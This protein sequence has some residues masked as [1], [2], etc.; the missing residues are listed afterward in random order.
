MI[1]AFF[2][3]RGFE[4]AITW[5]FGVQ[6]LDLRFAY[7]EKSSP[8]VLIVES[9]IIEIVSRSFEYVFTWTFYIGRWTFCVQK[10][11]R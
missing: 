8:S 2:V 4:Y 11:R 10:D 7:I 5:T 3:S 9:N 6:V 1:R